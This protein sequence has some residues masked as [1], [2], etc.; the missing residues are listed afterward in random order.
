MKCG[1]EAECL[2]YWVWAHPCCGLFSSAMQSFDGF[3]CKCG[4]CSCTFD[5]VSFQLSCT[6]SG[7]K[8]TQSE[9]P[10]RLLG[11]S[12]QIWGFPSLK[13]KTSRHQKVPWETPWEI[14]RCR[15]AEL[16]WET[17]LCWNSAPKIRECLLQEFTAPPKEAAWHLRRKSCCLLTQAGQ[18]EDERCCRR[19]MY[20]SS[21]QSRLQIEIWSTSL[22]W[23]SML[24]VWLPS[25]SLHTVPYPSWDY[26]TFRSSWGNA[27]GKNQKQI[28]TKTKTNQI[29]FFFPKAHIFCKGK[30]VTALSSLKGEKEHRTVSSH[31]SSWY[32]FSSGLLSLSTCLTGP[33]SPWHPLVEITAFFTS[34]LRWNTTVDDS[35][36][37]FLLQES[38]WNSLAC[39]IMEVRAEQNIPSWT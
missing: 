9:T 37:L 5:C 16:Q 32:N 34:L 4:L 35:S 15:L 38:L 19:K 30:H 28:K 27:L 8:I 25:I 7:M 13:I 11:F 2:N 6:F 10:A 17:S 12:S 33:P 21:L 20:P 22:S 29:N 3:N 24:T 1:L 36:P 31:R 18:P 14:N 26:F 23:G 39:V